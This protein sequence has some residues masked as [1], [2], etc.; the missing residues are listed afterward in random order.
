MGQRVDEAVR[1]LIHLMKLRKVFQS[2]DQKGMNRE[3]GNYQE[4]YVSPDERRTSRSAQK[5]VENLLE[6]LGK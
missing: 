5:A 1:R 2:G 6:T 4:W 3:L